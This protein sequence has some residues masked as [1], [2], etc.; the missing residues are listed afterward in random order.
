VLATSPES[1]AIWLVV[2]AGLYADHVP[3]AVVVPYATC[4]VAP[5]SVIH[6]M[7]AVVGV[8]LVATILDTTGD[9]VAVCAFARSA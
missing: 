6:V 3:Y 5:M 7:F 9:V 1:V 8:V 2:V 4:D